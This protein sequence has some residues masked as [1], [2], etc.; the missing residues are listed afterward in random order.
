[1]MSTQTAFIK[2]VPIGPMVFPGFLNALFLQNPRLPIGL[3]SPV[4]MGR[5]GITLIWA[6]LWQMGYS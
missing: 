5:T 6:T 3:P 1:M 4:N 2:T